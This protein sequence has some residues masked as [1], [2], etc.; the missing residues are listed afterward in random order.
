MALSAELIRKYNQPVPRYTSYPAVP[1]WE[2]NLNSSEWETLVKKAFQLIGNKEGITLYIHLP[3]CESLCTYCGCNKRITKNH[4][5]ED[6][7]LEAI[8]REWSHYLGLFEETPKI[9]GIHLGGGTPTFFSAQNLELLISKIL[10]SAEVLPNHEFS[11]EGHPNNTTFEHLQELAQLGFDRVSY[12]IQDFDLTVQKAIHRLQPF[13][14]VK[15]ATENAR[16]LGYSSIN[17]DLIYGLPHQTLHTLGETFEKVAELKPERIAFYSYAHLPSAF[18]AQKSFETFLPNENEK[19]ALYEFGKERLIKMGYEEVGM[20]HFALPDDPLCEA[21]RTGKLHRNFMGYTT[22][23]SEMLIG[24]GASSISDIGLGFAQNEKNIEAYEAI[25]QKNQLPVVRGHVQTEDDRIIRKLIMDLI[26]LG[27]AE[28][29]EGVWNQIPLENQR[30]LNEMMEE[31]LISKI[32]SS[33]SVSQSGMAVVRNIC[34]QFDLRL[35]SKKSHKVAF[36][37]AI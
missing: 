30:N 23:P 10:K 5:L 18:P 22:S 19:R 4:D 34:S 14:K 32:Y 33:I 13:E 9:A 31:G 11:F 1:H 36:S 8:I 12:G 35:N 16:K 28:I 7:Y 6:P 17:F 25:T 20:D 27:K 24:L 37:K 3:F 15:D 21:K 26:C 29:P 2:N